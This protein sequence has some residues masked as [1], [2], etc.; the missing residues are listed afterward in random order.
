MIIE[1]KK[2]EL[3]NKRVIEKHKAKAP[4]SGLF[5]YQKEACFIYILSGKG[6]FN[7]ATQQFSS[8]AGR[9]ILLKCGIYFAQWAADHNIDEVELFVVHLHRDLLKQLYKDQFPKKLTE[10]G[11]RDHVKEL[12]SN[13]LLEKY[14]ESL[15]FYFEN[16][17]VVNEELVEL[18]L[19][20]LIILLAETNKE[21]LQQLFAQIFSPTQFKIQDVVE[22][23]LFSNITIEKMAALSDM[24]LSKFKREFYKIYKDTPASYLRKR[25]LNKAAELLKLTDMNISEIAYET[26]YSDPNYFSKAFHQTYQASPIHYRKLQKVI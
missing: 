20:E 23:H 15:A 21:K 13:E 8:P 19:K 22:T 26:G 11:S 12:E 2:F 9:F 24:S 18:K 5:N 17:H 7:T 25:R 14:I 10:T 4:V 3:Y 1:Y 6:K 16:P